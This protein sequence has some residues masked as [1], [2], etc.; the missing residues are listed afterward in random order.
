ML[1]KGAGIS[2]FYERENV[3]ELKAIEAEARKAVAA[4]KEI[5]E[6]LDT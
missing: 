4:L 1:E 3:A 2:F 6:K 5:P